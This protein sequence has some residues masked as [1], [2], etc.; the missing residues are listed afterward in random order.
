MSATLPLFQQA[1]LAVRVRAR[2]RCG[3]QFAELYMPAVYI[4]RQ[5][6]VD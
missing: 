4:H 2:I 6:L 3:Y 1:F 5:A